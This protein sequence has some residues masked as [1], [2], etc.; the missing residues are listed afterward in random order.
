MSDSRKS[1]AL[2][3]VVLVACGVMVL[4]GQQTPQTAPYTAAQAA[5]GDTAYAAG[6][7]GAALDAYG[8]GFAK[9]RDAAFVYAMAECHKQLGHKDDA[10]QM[11]S[12]YL[13]ASG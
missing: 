8:E 3:S 11:F 4:T 9:T 6:S 7:F 12:M 10:K 13:A 1:F 5:A 2:A